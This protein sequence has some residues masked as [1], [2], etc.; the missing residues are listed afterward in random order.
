MARFVRVDRQATFIT[1]LYYPA[2]LAGLW[3]TSRH[4]FVNMW[5]H[6]LYAVGIRSGQPGAYTLQ[7]PEVM[8]PLPR[9][10][11]SKHR[12]KVHE[13]GRPK[14]TAC[15]LCETA[16]P[17]FCISI[18]P[19]E[20]DGS[21]EEKAPAEFR[22]DL[23]RCCFCGFCVEACPKDAIYMDTQIMELSSDRRENFVLLLPDLLDPKPIPCTGSE[24]QGKD[25]G[26]VLPHLGW[27]RLD[28]VRP[29][30]VDLSYREGQLARLQEGNPDAHKGQHA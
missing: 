19:M 2:V 18:T 23:D 21:P 12:I 27:R 24:F 13:D 9:V 25:L 1:A 29:V 14:C 7:Y 20:H 15:M 22:I 6:F 8:R 28:H 11:R 5:R 16:C 30:R 10:L 26:Q 4:F 17:D 3:V